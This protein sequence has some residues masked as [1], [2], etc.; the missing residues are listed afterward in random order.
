MPTFRKLGEVMYRQFQEESGEAGS[1]KGSRKNRVGMEEAA[2]IGS[3]F[4][5]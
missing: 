4:T 2:V 1:P 3:G 5:P